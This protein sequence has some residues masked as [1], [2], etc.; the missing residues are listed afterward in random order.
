MPAITPAGVVLERANAR[1]PGA[2][3]SP[4]IPGARAFNVV[5][6]RLSTISDPVRLQILWWLGLGDRSVTDLCGLVG[7]RQ[8]AVTHHLNIMRLRRIVAFRRQGRCHLYFVT[9]EGRAVMAAAELLF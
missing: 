3:S 4:A 2:R 1:A 9:E 6:D 8:Q 7:M 5:A